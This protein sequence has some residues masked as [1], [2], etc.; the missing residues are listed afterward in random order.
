MP[1]SHM[2]QLLMQLQIDMNKLTIDCVEV[3]SRLTDLL[4]FYDGRFHMQSEIKPV[5]AKWTS[6]LSAMSDSLEKF[7]ADAT[8]LG[9]YVDAQE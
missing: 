1:P 2:V 3:N 4:G 6:A 7:Q 8:K 5:V 9:E